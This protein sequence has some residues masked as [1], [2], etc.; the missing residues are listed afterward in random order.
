MV[1]VPIPLRCPPLFRSS[2]K[3]TFSL[4]WSISFIQAHWAEM[5]NSKTTWYLQIRSQL[6]TYQQQV[7]W[8]LYIAVNETW[9]SLIMSYL[10]IQYERKHTYKNKMPHSLG[11]SWT[12]A[13]ACSPK[14][15]FSEGESGNSKRVTL[16]KGTSIGDSVSGN[17]WTWEQV[18]NIYIYTHA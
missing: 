13:W 7:I 16:C 14:I 17:R 2:Q 6:E 12:P 5:F 11:P 3:Y 10:S 4:Q 1:G 15:Q 18:A 9:H 8:V